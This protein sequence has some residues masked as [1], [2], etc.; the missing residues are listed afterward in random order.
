VG[1]LKEK[2]LILDED[3]TKL[4]IKEISDGVCKKPTKYTN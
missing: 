3:K 2:N 4:D 1:K